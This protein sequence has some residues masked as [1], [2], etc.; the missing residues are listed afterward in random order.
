MNSWASYLLEYGEKKEHELISRLLVSHGILLN[1]FEER[2]IFKKEA[3]VGSSIIFESGIWSCNSVSMPI[4]EYWPVNSFTKDTVSV[5]LMLWIPCT[6]DYVNFLPFDSLE[7]HEREGSRT[8]ASYVCVGWGRVCPPAPQPNP[9]AAKPG[10]GL[11]ETW[12]E[13]I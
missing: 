6:Y 9:P 4:P 13:E 11:R 5:I 8:Q 12:W 10:R 1:A 7:W 3:L 2:L